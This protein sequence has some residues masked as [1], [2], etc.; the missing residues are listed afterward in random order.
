MKKTEKTVPSYLRPRWTREEEMFVRTNVDTM[1]VSD[2]AEQLGKSELAVQLFIHRRQIAVGTKVKRNLVTEM[3]RLKFIHPENFRPTRLF[4]HTV[5]ITPMR[6]YDICHR[7]RVPGTCTL[8]RR[9]ARGSLREPPA[10]T[11]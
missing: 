7:D 4:Y 1:K 3:L 8:F 2:M 5:G 11:F 10:L 6:W 9:H